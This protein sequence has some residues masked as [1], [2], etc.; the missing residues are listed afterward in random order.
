MPLAMRRCM[1]ACTHLHATVRDDV[2]LSL[3]AAWH[4]RPAAPTCNAHIVVHPTLRFAAVQD[5]LDDVAKDINENDSLD[6]LQPAINNILKKPN[7]ARKNM[8][9]AIEYLPGK[10]QQPAREIV[11]AHVPT[12][13]PVLAVLPGEVC[14]SPTT[15][16]CRCWSRCGLRN[17]WDPDSAP[18]RRWSMQHRAAHQSA[19]HGRTAMR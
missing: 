3:E 7:E 14:R 12:A 13:Q 5:L 15:A 6:S 2:T 19:L 16:L 4:S 8:Y 9:S 10:Q 18:Y 1:Q 11:G 17:I